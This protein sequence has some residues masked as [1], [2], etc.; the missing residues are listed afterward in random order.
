MYP[1]Q[2]LDAES[3]AEAPLPAALVPA[4][5]RGGRAS[6]SAWVA[7]VVSLGVL[8]AAVNQVRTLDL[9]RM[10][11]LMPAAPGFWLALV[12]S[13]FMLPVS[14]WLI[15][16]RAWGLPLSGFWPLLRKRLSNEI[17]L[18]YS[19]ELYF[20]A[21]A[22]RHLRFAGAPFG[23]IKDVTMLSAQ[24][25]NLATLAMVAIAWPWFGALHLGMHARGMISSCALV[26]ALSVPMILFRRRLF[27]LP[28]PELWR[29]A[30]IHMVRI[31]AVLLL[32]GF[33]WHEALPAVA[34][35]WWVLLAA[36]RQLLSRLP[37]MPNKDIAFAGLTVYLLGPATGLADVVALSATVILGMHL[38]LG[39][40]LATAELLAPAEAA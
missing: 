36:L 4:S 15:Y 21:W 1:S 34:L 20:Y 13:Y 12:A 38:F 37:L 28:A 16:R 27:T 25:G 39:V 30:A 8:V 19:G 33:A 22:R 11:A 35:G 7:P 29:I 3:L 32:T 17:L 10:I 6:W 40:A 24:A 26:L 18:G 2:T 31:A 9:H 23:V 14:E 5:V